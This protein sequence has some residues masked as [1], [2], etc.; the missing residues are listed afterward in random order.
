MGQ[1]NTRSSGGQLWTFAGGLITNRLFRGHVLT[2]YGDETETS[3]LRALVLRPK[4]TV[5]DQFA[6]GSR[7]EPRVSPRQLWSVPSGPGHIVNEASGYGISGPGTVLKFPHMVTA[8]G[9][10]GSD[11][12]AR[13]VT[14]LVETD[15]DGRAWYRITHLADTRYCLAV[16]FVT[17]G[18]VYELVSET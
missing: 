1:N 5:R 4:Y 15:A 17:L 3:W 12:Y 9:S 13:W 16:D 18:V 2:I 7:A 11:V 14:E 8:G 6:D 10:R